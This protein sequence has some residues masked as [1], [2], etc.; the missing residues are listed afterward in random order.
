MGDLFNKVKDLKVPDSVSNLPT[1][2]TELKESYLETTATVEELRIEVD[3]LSQE[4]YLLRKENETL[5]EA[6]GV[7]IKTDDLTAMLKPIEV[8]ASD[9]VSAFKVDRTAAEAKYKGKF[10]KVVGYISNF[11]S[12]AQS[13]E[14]HL[15][16]EGHDSKVRCVLQ[17]GA[18]LY[19][20]V[21]PT[22]GRMISRNDHRVMLSVGQPVAVIGTCTGV[23]LNVDIVNCRIDGLTEVKKVDAP[24]K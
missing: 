13:A 7:K 5:R 8:S 12:G 3:N 18:E 14:M 6:V 10:L 17:V 20:D 19:V 4:V 16:A 2:I 1:Q 15:K 22:Q 24:K 9:L 21:L 23:G 11:E